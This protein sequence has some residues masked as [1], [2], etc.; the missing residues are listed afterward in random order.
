MLVEWLKWLT[1][2]V[3]CYQDLKKKK[4]RSNIT[5]ITLN[6]YSLRFQQAWNQ[7]TNESTTD[8]KLQRNFPGKRAVPLIRAESES[9]TYYGSRSK[10]YV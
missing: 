1:R 6:G 10:L 3:S 2:E 8:Q 7:Q 4:N 5:C 9:R